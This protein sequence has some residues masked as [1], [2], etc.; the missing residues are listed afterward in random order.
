MKQELNKFRIKWCLSSYF[1]LPANLFLI[2]SG[3]IDPI[4]APPG[5][6][7]NIDYK[8]TLQIITQPTIIVYVKSNYA[9]LTFNA[10]SATATDS[11]FDPVSMIC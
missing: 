1:P 11:Q 8:V 5:R 3:I 7:N 10:F 9:F 4:R 2:Q 6:F